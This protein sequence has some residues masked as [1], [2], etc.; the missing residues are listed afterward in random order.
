ME[1]KLAQRENLNH[2]SKPCFA[3]ANEDKKCVNAE[4]CSTATPNMKSKSR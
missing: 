1:L 4:N 3:N 2:E